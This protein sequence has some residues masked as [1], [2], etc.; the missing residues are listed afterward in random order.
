MTIA[1]NPQTREWHL[2]NGATS[3]VLA[4]LENGWIGQL[5]AGA[6]LSPD[7]SY[8]HLYPPFA[9]FDN[10]MPEP[11]PLAV[12]VPG[13]GDFRVP[14]LVVETRDG[15]TVLDLQY[16]THRILRGKPAL[17][18]TTGVRGPMPATY[19]EHEAD[20]DTLEIDCT[21]A[22]SRITVTLR[23]TLFAAR[24]V[25]ARSMTI[26][27]EGAPV[28][29]RTAMSATL[30]LP[31]GAWTMLQ[32]SGVWARERHLVERPLAPGRVAVSSVRGGSGPEHNP[33]IALRRPTTTEGAGEAWGVMLAWSGNFLAEAEVEPF[34]TARV[35]IGENPETF[36][37]RLEHDG[38]FTTPE[39]LVAW[40]DRGL[41]G[42]SDA[43]H[44]VLRRNMARGPWRDAE[45]PV[46]LNNWEGTYFDFDHDRLVAMAAEAKA[47][48]IELFVL[49]DGWFG[50]R[51]DDHRGLGDWT[52]NRTK[53]RRGLA[54]LGEEIH[55][56]GLQFGIWIEP[57][58]VNADSDLF[59]ERPDWAIG[60]PG[61]R[62]TA[63][64]HQ[65]VLDLA[66]PE[67]VDHLFDVISAALDEAKVDYVKWDWNRFIT[68]P[69]TPAVPPERQ[70][71]F[72]HRYVYGLYDLYERL[73]T[74]F[75]GVLWESCASGGARFDA[76][77]LAWAPQAWTSDDTDAVERLRIQYGTSLAYP[78]SSMG[79]HVSDI[80]NH[81][82]GRTP[83]LD[84]RAAVAMFGTFGYELDPT[85]LTGE[86]RAAVQRQ[87][88]FFTERRALI[89]GGRFDRLRSPF[90]GDG[91]E[92]AWMVTAA[93]GARALAAF[94]R[95]LFRPLPV[96]DRLRLRGLDPAARYE[97]TRWTSFD[98]PDLRFIRGGDDLM[99]IGIGI[100][101]ADGEIVEGDFPD[102][103]RLVRHDFTFRL[104][105]IRR[106]TA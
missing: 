49:D 27:N 81:Q 62:R 86:E 83:S 105:D 94:Y 72:F 67:V 56:M 102:G 46:L 104:Y 9:G 13:V 51:S 36:A 37:W 70:G 87:V 68:E 35:R 96:R 93:D 29:I 52:V 38:V 95:V 4:V 82:T 6:P 85:R 55:A 30:D 71:E 44:A 103:M 100:E 92:T 26:A 40:S 41:G 77:L 59:R 65:L 90:E 84:F 63:Q 88:A 25:V 64:R 61:R 32:L 14:G 101:P 48:G 75:P 45:R 15:A 8:R 97:I 33:F 21:D 57:E 1:W 58:M 42:M 34:G 39:A 66:I 23:W 50:A 80:P 11:V 79:A 22:R 24:P 3:W 10:R 73:V 43:L 28:T 31:D 99:R 76:G 98:G 19:A 5:H 17:P 60:V 16:A 74:R 69:W 78:V 18:A 54:G 91:N 2:H 106:V 89:S 12:P 7:A 53:L 47:M 20:A